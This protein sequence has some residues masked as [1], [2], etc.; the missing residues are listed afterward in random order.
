MKIGSGS[1][2]RSSAKKQKRRGD[3]RWIA[4]EETRVNIFSRDRDDDGKTDGGVSGFFFR[5]LLFFRERLDVRT[6]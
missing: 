3:Y 2:E 6:R 1:I 4:Y 5:F